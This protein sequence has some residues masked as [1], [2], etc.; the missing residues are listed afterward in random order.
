VY[1]A[2]NVPL[3]GVTVGLTFGKLHLTQATGPDGRFLF[4]CLPEGQ[5]EIF[6]HHRQASTAGEFTLTL[7]R[8]KPSHVIAELETG[9][10]K[11]WHLREEPSYGYVPDPSAR[12]YTQAKIAQLPSALHLWALLGHTEVSA[13]VERFDVAGMHGD[14]AMLFGSRGGSWSQNRVVWNGFN[15]TSGDGGRTLL[16]PDLAA[17]AGTTHEARSACLS[18]SGAVGVAGPPQGGASLPSEGHTF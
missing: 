9:S 2:D 7:A 5:V 17:V 1:A 4:C 11:G 13:T 10:A 6:F 3:A 8:A 14:D 12:T 16:L 15:V 18:P